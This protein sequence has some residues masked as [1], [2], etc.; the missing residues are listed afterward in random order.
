MHSSVLILCGTKGSR[1]DEVCE[2]WS[3]WLY[4]Q[5]GRYAVRRLLARRYEMCCERQDVLICF[6][7]TANNVRNRLCSVLCWMWGEETGCSASVLIRPMAV[8]LTAVRLRCQA[9]GS[10]TH[11][12]ASEMSGQ[13]QLHS[14]QCVW[15]VRPMAVSLNVVRLGWS[16][17]WQ[18]HSQQC[19]WVDQANGSCTHS[20]ASGLIRP[21]AVALTAVRLSWSGQ[22]QLHSL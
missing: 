10:C 13:W 12:S 2:V 11:C 16:G 21:M 8:A 6:C 17:Q 22:W 19:V 1:T 3:V 7:E 14:L 15:D 5:M 20:S 9:N 18:L 4:N